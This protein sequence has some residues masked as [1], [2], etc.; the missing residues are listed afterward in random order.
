MYFP[1]TSIALI[2]ALAS[3]SVS[4]APAPP[5]SFTNS[6]SLHLVPPRG[7]KIEYLVDNPELNCAINLY[8]NHVCFGSASAVATSSQ[9]CVDVSAYA[10]LQANCANAVFDEAGAGAK[11]LAGVNPV[12][13]SR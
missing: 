8:T 10:S 13:A 9:S 12:G 6:T 2:L 4:A 11:T 5:Y 3:A 7:M 1:R